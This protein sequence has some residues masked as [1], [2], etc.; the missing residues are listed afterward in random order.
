MLGLWIFRITLGSL[1]AAFNRDDVL[2]F[3]EAATWMMKYTGNDVTPLG[4]EKIDGSRG[5]AAA[6]SVISY[7][8][9]TLA[10]SPKGWIISDGYQV[11][12][13]DNNIPD[14]SFNEITSDQFLRGFSGFW[15]EDRDV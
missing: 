7:W 2:F 3:T 15:D 9:R 12:R 5:S 11:D 14:F 1:G 6:F 4:L 8:N 10:A 13:M